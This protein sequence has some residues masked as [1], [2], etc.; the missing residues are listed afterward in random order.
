MSIRVDGQSLTIEAVVRVARHNEKVELAPEALER[1][2]RCRSMLEK[3]L[4]ARE[5]MYG[6][7][8]GIGE[9]SESCSTTSSRAVPAIF[10]LQP[11]GRY[12]RPVPSSTCA[13]PC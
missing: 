6:T 5:I 7:N 4:E 1:I 13:P 10:D 11:R 8:T 2:N 9:F 3:K 12:R